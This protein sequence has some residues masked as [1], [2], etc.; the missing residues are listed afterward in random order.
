MN[1]KELY[2]FILSH[3]AIFANTLKEYRVEEVPHDQYK[4]KHFLQ[5]K[6]IRIEHGIQI[7]SAELFDDRF[8]DEYFKFDTISIEVTENITGM[9]II[10]LQ[11]PGLGGCSELKCHISNI[12]TILTNFSNQIYNLIVPEYTIPAHLIQ[13]YLNTIEVYN[14]RVRTEK[15]SRFTMDLEINNIFQ[16]DY[17]YKYIKW[18]FNAVEK[19]KFQLSW[20]TLI[21]KSNLKWTEEQ[22]IKYDDF[23]PKKKMHLI[24]LK[25]LTKNHTYLII[26]M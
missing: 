26:R 17:F 3:Y 25:F 13:Y 18:D 5:D 19:Y 22:L 2:G 4:Q 9:G 7:H 24:I 1:T 6:I 8:K 10:V 20:K 14:T 15:A 12:E 23:L 16:F 21:E 11:R